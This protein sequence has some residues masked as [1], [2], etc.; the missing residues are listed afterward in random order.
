MQNPAE[1]IEFEELRGRG[2]YMPTAPDYGR[3]KVLQNFLENPAY[4]LQQ[5]LNSDL[6]GGN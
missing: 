6:R 2:A 3:Y 4:S 5:Q 1:A